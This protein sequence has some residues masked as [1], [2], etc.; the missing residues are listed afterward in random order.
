MFFDKDE[1]QTILE[2]IKDHEAL[3]TE[4][5]AYAD[6]EKVRAMKVKID[7]KQSNTEETKKQEE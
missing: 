3:I 4:Y 5:S 6:T 2:L 7:G 1:V